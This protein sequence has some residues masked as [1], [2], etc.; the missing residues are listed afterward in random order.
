MFKNKKLLAV[1]S[2]LTLLPILVGLILWN[3]FPDRI[4]THWNL[5]GEAD[6][7]GNVSFAVFVPPLLMLA[8]HWFCIL[9]TSLDKGN[10]GRNRKPLALVYWIIPVV[11]NI[12]SLTMYGLALGWKFSPTALMIVP[13]GLMFA[14]IG[15]FMPKMKMNSTM[16]IKVPWAYSSEENW[17]ATHRLGGRLWLAGGLAIAVAGLLPGDLS[18]WVILIAFAV[19]TVVPIGYSWRYYKMQKARG[20]VLL[21]FPAMNAKATKYSMVFLVLIF[22]FVMVL[23][24]TGD[25]GVV[26]GDTSFT[27]EAS[28]YDDLTVD[29]AVIESME[30]REGN[31]PG[32]RVGG[33]GSFRLLM[34]FFQN[35]EFGTHTRYTYYKPEACVILTTARQTL[36][37]SGSTAAETRGIYETLLAKTNL[38]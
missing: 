3:Q 35:E 28:F 32:A 15:N 6:G 38:P 4:T 5:A 8:G 23:M 1:T 33:F 19:M 29:Y 12:S 27:I 7:S 30:Y 25:I 24:F 11:S 16:G 13:L 31:V 10:Q 21:P 36:V 14:A 22:A 34:G 26:F 20:D 37:L 18:F 17:N 2:A 9:C